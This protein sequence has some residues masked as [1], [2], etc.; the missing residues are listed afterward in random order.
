[1]QAYKKENGSTWFIGNIEYSKTL[2]NS[3]Q[4]N[5]ISQGL[6][7]CSPMAKKILAYV[8]ADLNIVKWNNSSHETYEAI[9]KCSDFAKS[10]GFQRTGTKQ[11][12]L[13]KQ[14]LIEL[15]QSYIAIDT[16]DK[17]E[18]FS[19]VTH[20]IYA[21]KEHKIAVEINHHLGQALME[22]KKGYTAIQLL[23][24][25][26]LQSFYAMRFYE[27]ALSFSGFSGKKGNKKNFW[28]F[29]YSVEQIRQLFQIKD[30]EYS[31]RMTNFITYVIKK[32]LEEVGQKTNLK[33]DFEKIKDGKNVIGFRFLCSEKTEFEPL[34]IAKTDTKEI[35][36]E[37]TEINAEREQTEKEIAFYKDNYP[38]LWAEKYNF[39]RSQNVLPFG[40]KIN[41]ENETLKLVKQE[42]NI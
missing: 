17:F 24:L 11:K 28:Y 26:K 12:E 30:S 41:D 20:S 14:A 40:F 6:Y 32:P 21:D 42:L 35:K 34:K 1:M 36:N 38:E 10:L 4:P 8:I 31:G 19:W 29:E 37:K 2:E 18:T 22:Y 3:L 7:R 39:V 15:Q 16:G 5:Q 27:L 25:G 13:I 9:F 33:I 23:E